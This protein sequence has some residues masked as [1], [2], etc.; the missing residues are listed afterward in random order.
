MFT[1]CEII[2][3]GDFNSNLDKVNDDIAKMI[4]GFLNNYNLIRCDDLFPS[5]KVITYC[6]LSLSHESQID[7]IATS[8]PHIV[9]SYKVLD[10][11]INFSD[12]FPSRSN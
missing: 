1:D 7:Y 2:L 5:Q 6:N 4:G 8:S 9:T 12:R 10:P 3:G 11:D